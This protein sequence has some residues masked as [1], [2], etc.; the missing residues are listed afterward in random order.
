MKNDDVI[1]LRLPRELK[2]QLKIL[3]KQ[4][5]KKLTDLHRLLLAAAVKNKFKI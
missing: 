1:I 3:A 5:K 2:A 4:N